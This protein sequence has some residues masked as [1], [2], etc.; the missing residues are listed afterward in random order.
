M[1]A[2]MWSHLP[3]LEATLHRGVRAVADANRAGFYD[4]EID[5]NWYYIHI[6]SRISGVYLV[7]AGRKPVM[8]SSS[9]ERMFVGMAR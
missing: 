3:Q 5:N 7:A 2:A 4:I 6:P 9:E 1:N 8:T